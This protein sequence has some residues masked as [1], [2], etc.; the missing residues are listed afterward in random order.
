MTI[1]YWIGGGQPPPYYRSEQLLFKTTGDRDI[2]E[3]AIL[4]YHPR[5]TPAE[6]T[7]VDSTNCHYE[8]VKA[9]AAT[10]LATHLEDTTFAEEADPQVGSVISHEINIQ[11]GEVKLQKKF[12][13]QLPAEFDTFKDLVD[14]IKFKTIGDGKRTWRHKGHDIA[15]PFNDQAP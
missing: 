13:R 7:Q 10:L 12:Y 5:L 6:V 2:V 3:L 15:N 8:V 1:E 9:M 14:Q 11:I 4:R